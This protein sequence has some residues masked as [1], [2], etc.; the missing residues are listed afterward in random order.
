MFT[1]IL[2]FFF[3]TGLSNREKGIDTNVTCEYSGDTLEILLA[4]MEFWKSENHSRESPPNQR[5]MN[6][7]S[8]LKIPT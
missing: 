8:S 4:L 1:S 2:G 6:I 7:S 5:G 3:Y